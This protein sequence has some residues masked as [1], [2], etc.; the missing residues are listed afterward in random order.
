MSMPSKPRWP[1]V[2]PT[3]PCSAT[4]FS[5]GFLRV[6]GWFPISKSSRNFPSRYDVAA[7]RQHRWARGDWQLLP[8]IF[9]RS[10][11]A[12][13]MRGRRPLPLIGL[14]KMLDNLRRTLSAPASV[15]ALIAGWALL[16]N[17]SLLWSVLHRIDDCR[18]G[19]AADFRQPSCRSRSGV[20]MRS[21][22]RALRKDIWLAASQSALLTIFLAHQAWLMIDAI[23]RTLFRLFVSR[24]NLLQWVTA[25]QAKL[26]SELDL[27]RLLPAHGRRRRRRDRRRGA[28]R[29]LSAR[30]MGLGDAVRDSSGSPLLPSPYGSA[31]PRLWPGDLTVTDAD[32]RALR[33]IARRTWRYFETFVTA[34]DHMLPPDNFQEDPRPVLAHRTSP[35]N[36]GLYLLSAVSARD[37]GWAG[38]IETVDRLEAT[39]ETMG[40][41]NQFRGHFFNWYDTRDLRPLDPRYVSSV[42]SG[43]LAAHLIA[44][45]NVCREWIVE[46]APGRLPCVGIADAMQLAREALDELPD[47][48]GNTHHRRCAAQ[49]RPRCARRCARRAV[50]P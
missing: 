13:A 48:T 33:L 41:L 20:K 22:F 9:G 23:S 30:R 39:L 12:G 29:V 46:R 11:A 8:W 24:R 18:A 21:H 38:T 27:Y 3:G 16:G 47:R 31:S 40:R 32:A 4:I 44:L 37:F 5:R 50:G 45:A 34:D 42:D 26:S 17:G 1:V 2:C 14:W 28:G 6:R 25:A 43:N 10:D 15:A 7:A 36:M 35:T 49:T 19:A